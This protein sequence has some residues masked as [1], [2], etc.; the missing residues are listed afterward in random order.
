MENS[1]YD[2]GFL[3]AVLDADDDFHSACLEV[4]DAERNTFLPDVVLPEL[5]YLIKRELK[6]KD[7][8]KFLRAVAAGGFEILRTTKNDL[9]RAAE[10]FRNV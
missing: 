2:T 8:T 7:L 5:A 1:I 3:L 4:Y 10:I 9:E 6:L